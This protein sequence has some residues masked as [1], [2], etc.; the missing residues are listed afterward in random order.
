MRGDGYSAGEFDGHSMDE[1][2]RAVFGAA[3][4]CGQVRLSDCEHTLS[5]T[6]M[7]REAIM[8]EAQRTRARVPTQEGP[9][10]VTVPFTKGGPRQ[11]FF[12][13]Q[14]V[15]IVTR[16]GRFWPP[17]W[18]ASVQCT[19]DLAAWSPSC[20]ILGPLPRQLPAERP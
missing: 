13:L 11:D 4:D 20:L 2:D 12:R 8:H 18:Q 15:T 5:S 6:A 9:S 17:I 14:R 3:N 19:V 10:F 16:K 7:K 1:Y